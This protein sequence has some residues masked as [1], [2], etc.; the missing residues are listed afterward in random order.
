[1]QD[2]VITS[3]SEFVNYVTNENNCGHWIYRGVSDQQNHKLIPSV[4]RIKKFQGDDYDIHQ[5]EKELLNKFML[6]SYG[7]L[8][9]LPKNNWEWLTLG[10]HY[11][12]PTRLLDWTTSPLVAAYFATKPAFSSDGEIMDCCKNGVAI[13]AVH[14]CEY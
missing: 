10:Q 4:G 7:Q 11:G 13:Y 3:F 1:M 9:H 5:N 12:L 14:F 2:K 8:K 6:R